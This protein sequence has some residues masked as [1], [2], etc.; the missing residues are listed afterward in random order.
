LEWDLRVI[1]PRSF[2]EQRGLTYP[3]LDP[4]TPAHVVLSPSGRAQSLLAVH[5]VED[6]QNPYCVDQVRAEVNIELEFLDFGETQTGTGTFT[7]D[8]S[9]TVLNESLSL[10]DLGDDCG[11][12]LPSKLDDPAQIYCSSRAGDGQLLPFPTYVGTNRCGA[13]ET[14]PEVPIETTTGETWA[15]LFQRPEVRQPVPLSCRQPDGSVTPLLT[16]SISLAVADRVCDVFGTQAAASVH[17]STGDTFDDLGAAMGIKGG[18]CSDDG[19][20]W[21]PAIEPEPVVPVCP[22]FVVHFEKPTLNSVLMM[23]LVIHDDGSQTV[24]VEYFDPRYK[25]GNQVPVPYTDCSGKLE[26]PPPP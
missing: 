25:W 17:L 6:E 22:T 21:D 2:F 11:V 16:A 20:H 1:P 9:G 12:L 3:A 14:W 23:D 4:T 19:V 24:H 10:G 7:I 8:A 15:V 26:I 13:P 5:G 18:P